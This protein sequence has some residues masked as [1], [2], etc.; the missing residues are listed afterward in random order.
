MMKLPEPLL[1]YVN[2]FHQQ[3]SEL[4]LLNVS[5]SILVNII[6]NNKTQ[7]NN[8]FMVGMGTCSLLLRLGAVIQLSKRLEE[9]GDDQDAL[10]MKQIIENLRENLPS[11]TNW[12][13]IWKIAAEKNKKWEDFVIAEK[14]KVSM[15]DNFITFRNKFVHGIIKID[16]INLKEIQSGITLLSNLISK[17]SKLFE[18]TSII[19]EKNKYFFIKNKNKICLEPFVKKGKSNGLPYI[20][21]GLYE[22]KKTPELINT[23]YGDIEKKDDS[24][25]YDAFFQPMINVL[26]SGYNQIFDH[27]NRINYYTKCFVGRE[28]ECQ[29]ILNWVISDEKCNILPLY[30]DAG[31]GKG[32][33]VANLISELQDENIPVLFHFCGSGLQ[34]N[35]QAVIVHLILQAKK[36][37]LWKIEDKE[38]EDKVR[39]IPTKLHEQI[40]LLHHLLDYCFLPTRKNIHKKLVIIVDGLD[41]ASISYPSLNIS[42]W[43]NN[44]DNNGE[45]IDSW[46]SSDN[47]KWVFTFRQGFYQFPDFDN[48][49]SIEGV[50]PLM[51]L[52]TKSIQEALKIFSP[53]KEFIA[54]VIERGQVL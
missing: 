49:I 27:S 39:Q 23:F 11:D 36:Q 1:T 29:S 24:S 28:K 35:L 40:I 9:G 10:L 16:V 45:I 14:G 19:E 46:K 47:I 33:L 31:M 26:N 30:S 44:Y 37:Q 34:N 13:N 18:N 6:Q 20:F 53:S 3:Q 32:A 22:N 5:E 51:G 15:I 17:A 41:E 12:K 4:N 48:I 54:K 43:F 52:N 8:F 7:L 25:D 2:R 50:Q 38:I 21:Q 42:D